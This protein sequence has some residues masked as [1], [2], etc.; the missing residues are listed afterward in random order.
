MTQ[1]LRAL[2]FVRRTSPLGVRFYDAVEGKFVADG[3]SVSAHP[4]GQPALG[5]RSVANRSAVHTFHDLPGSRGLQLPELTPPNASVSLPQLDYRV[6]VIDDAGRYLPFSFAATLP[7]SGL[8]ELDCAAAT[9]AWS[10][11]PSPPAGA[12]I[13]LF[14]APARRAAASFAC[15]RAE[16]WDATRDVPAAW[17]LVEARAGD[18]PVQRGLCDARGRLALFFAYPEPVDVAPGAASSSFP[19]APPLMEQS[20]PLE[21]RVHYAPEQAVPPVPDLCRTL[22]QPLAAA[23]TD[24]ARSVPLGP[25]ELKFGRELTVRTHD[26]GVPLS[27]LWVTSA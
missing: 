13:T 25:L 26:G 16:L 27:S 8:F 19:L 11:P 20:W 17:A 9:P 7:Q 12:C 18:G 24:T 23:W 6:T 22:T 1:P 21:L 4:K 15:L 3:L 2:D 5:K 14:S 10:R